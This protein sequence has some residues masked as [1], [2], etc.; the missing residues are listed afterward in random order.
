MERL[1]R[2]Q[3]LILRAIDSSG[4]NYWQI[5][6]KSGVDF[7]SFTDGLKSL[8]EDKHAFDIQ[9]Q[10]HLN[11]SGLE[12][13][14]SQQLDKYHDPTCTNCQGRTIDPNNTDFQNLL[15]YIQPIAAQRGKR[16]EELDQAFA[17]AEV[18]A[19][20]VILMRRNC[21]LEN[22]SVCV[23]GDDDCM[24][25]ALAYTGLPKRVTV[26]EYDQK[27]IDL[28]KSLGIPNLEVEQIDL[29]ENL[30]KHF[31]KQYD[32][33]FTDPTPTLPVI[34]L[35]LS[36]GMQSLRPEETSSAYF[37]LSEMEASLQKWK[38]VQQILLRANFVIT[39]IIKGFNTYE[40]EGD[41]LLSSDWRVVKK[42]PISN[43]PKP[44]HHWYRSSLVRITCLGRILPP[45]K[46]KVEWDSSMY[47]D[48]ELLG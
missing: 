22:R 38:A 19:S 36:R 7:S 44:E 18:T 20:R 10:L 23:L 3:R 33:F 41:W 39:D 29:R 31:Q 42:A 43:I 12:L 15:S 47:M 48:E 24:G 13:L 26:L 5:L 4:A 30:P 2:V 1:D 32:T 40:L 6:T 25:V 8:L 45:I 27:L 35:F 11:P 46:E 16:E 17:P 9:G 37:T 14:H 21:D 34:S 28:Y